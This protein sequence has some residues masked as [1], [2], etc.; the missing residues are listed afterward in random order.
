MITDIKIKAVQRSKII[1]GQFRGLTK[2][3]EEERYCLDIMTQSL[4]IQNSLKSLNKLILE[5]HMKTHVMHGMSEGNDKDKETLISE[6][7]KLYEL[8]NV[9]G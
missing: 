3:I 5:N 9:R 2:A 7:L 6:L 1:E 8:T 4:A